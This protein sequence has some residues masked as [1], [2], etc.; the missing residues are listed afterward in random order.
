MLTTLTDLILYSHIMG[1]N[2]GNRTNWIS[3]RTDN[4]NVCHSESG[5]A[6]KRSLNLSI[7]DKEII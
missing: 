3:G 4:W 6:R 5:Y 2:H 1:F 7:N